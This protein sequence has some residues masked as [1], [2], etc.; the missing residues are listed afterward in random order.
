MCDAATTLDTCRS[1]VGDPDLAPHTARQTARV[2]TPR[3]GATAARTSS[4]RA[5]RP[6]RTS[7]RAR[8]ARVRLARRW[9]LFA[10]SSPAPLGDVARHGPGLSERSVFRDVL[11]RQWDARRR[12]SPHVGRDVHRRPSPDER[13]RATQRMRQRARVE[14]R[15]ESPPVRQRRPVRVRVTTGATPLSRFR[16]HRPRQQHLQQRVRPARR[17]RAMR[18]H[19][20]R[21]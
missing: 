20:G 19:R 18:H 3:R 5:S 21:R 7:E 8:G 2:S 16:V 15:R 14:R 4:E 11:R 13:P 17:Q 10:F 9:S 6:R 1:G 12:R